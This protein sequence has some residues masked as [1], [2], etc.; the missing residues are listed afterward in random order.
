MKDPSTGGASPGN[1][2]EESL[3]T[4]EKNLKHRRQGCQLVMDILGDFS[5]GTLKR[6][7]FILSCFIAF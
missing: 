6:W 5:G 4:L 7:G 3:A 1:A 2:Q